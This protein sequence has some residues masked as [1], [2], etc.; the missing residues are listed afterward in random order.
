MCSTFRITDQYYL[1]VSSVLFTKFLF[2]GCPYIYCAEKYLSPY[3]HT[4]APTPTN[5]QESIN[6]SKYVWFAHFA[7]SVT[8]ALYAKQFIIKKYS[9]MITRLQTSIREWK[10]AK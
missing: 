7:R 3:A 1:W 8:A 10:L 6:V 5:V 9:T 4:N 2:K